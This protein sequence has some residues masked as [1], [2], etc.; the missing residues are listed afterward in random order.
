MEVSEPKVKVFCRVRKIDEGQTIHPNFKISGQNQSIEIHSDEQEKT[1][2]NYSFFRVLDQQQDQVS[3]YDQL[4]SS[5]L[6]NLFKKGLNSLIFSYGVTN[7]GKT[8]SMIGQKKNPGLLPRL[9]SNLIKEVDTLNKD[10]PKNLQI[11]ISMECCE[12]YNKKVIDLLQKDTGK[13]TAHTSFKDQIMRSAKS[14]HRSQLS[15]TRELISNIQDFKLLLARYNSKKKTRA[16]ELNK[17]SSRSHSIFK[18]KLST[19]NYDKELGEIAVIDL[20]GSERAKRTQNM[21]KGLKEGADIN[22]SLLILGRCLSA[23]SDGKFPPFRDSKLT[24]HLQNYFLQRCQINILIN[25]N[26]R[27]EDFSETKRVLE[28]S[29]LAQRVTNKKCLK[30]KQKDSLDDM[31]Q[32][33]Q[34]MFF[35]QM[36]T[37]DDNKVNRGS[38][39]EMTESKKREIENLKNMIESKEKQITLICQQNKLLKKQNIDLR[40]L[41][42]ELDEEKE[43][44]KSRLFVCERSFNSTEY[45]ESSQS[46]LS[47]S[48]DILTGFNLQS[49]PSQKQNNMMNGLQDK[50]FNIDENSQKCHDY[51]FKTPV[52]HFSKF[53]EGENNPTFKTKR[54]GQKGISQ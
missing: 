54:I 10:K 34:R 44:Y 42:Y 1:Y 51:G 3:V 29:R 15:S 39:G 18:I 41:N 6:D 22:F 43:Y 53:K 27:T 23:I 32:Q 47:S 16:T 13:R 40:S 20:A 14:Q 31:M 25:I 36:K 9:I 4:G 24:K 8:Y 37:E 12:V 45:I 21:G 26:P 48:N 19:I 38:G 50:V 11:L 17:V 46:S 5:F 28:F 33:Y 49:K 52:K 35:S 7:S 30:I 2:D